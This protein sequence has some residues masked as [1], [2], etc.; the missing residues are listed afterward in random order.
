MKKITFLF[1]CVCISSLS[2]FAQ[3]PSSTTINFDSGTWPS[4]TT[5]V[6]NIDVDIS[7][8]DGNYGMTFG[9][10]MLN[11]TAP[12][13]Y[14]VVAGLWEFAR[15]S[16][17]QD[18]DFATIK[19][20]DG[21]EFNMTEISLRFGGA[22]TVDINGF[23]DGALVATDSFTGGTSF[24]VKTLAPGFA[25]VD[26]IQFQFTSGAA[27]VFRMDD[28][29]FGIA[30]VAGDTTPPV[31]ENS[32]PNTSSIN[33]TNFVLGTDIDEEGT[34]YYVV[35]PDGAVAPTSAEVKAGTG[36]G[37]VVSLTSGNA[38]VSSGA[39]TNDFNVAGLTASTDYDV[40]VV[41]EDDEGTPNLQVT[42]S[43]VDVTT[44]ALI[45]LTIT[46]ITGDDKVYDGTTA[47]TAT[48]TAALSGVV[49]GDDVVLGGTPV[50][51]FA[52]S[53]VGTGITINASGY[54]ISG[55]DAGNYTLTQPTLSGDITSVSLTIT[56]IT[57]DD[58]VYDGTT[59]ATAAGT[60]TLS[61]VVSGDDVVLGGTPVFAFAS[62]DVG[63]GITINGSGYIISG[64][65]AGNYTLTQPTLSG[66]ITSVSLTITGITGDDKV[67]DGTTAATAIGTA[68]LSGVVSGD[69]V[70]LGGT[71]AFAFASSD[72]GTGI[73]I[74]ASGYAI[75]GTDAGNYILTQ[76]TLSADI[77]S[78]SLTIT[79]ITGD[80][81]VYDGTTAATAI[82]TAALSG[83]VSGDDVVLG[84][85]PVFAF[86]SSDVGTGITINASGYAI[87]GTDA[88]NYTLTQPTLS[89]DITSVSLTVTGITGDDKVYDGTTAATATGTA[90][91]SGVV[92]GDDVVL[93]GTPVFAFV[94]SDVGTG[95][96][97]NASGY[98]ISGTDAGN[99]TL[100]QPTL[101][102]DITSVSLT[103]T[104]ITGDDKA[105]DGSTTATVSGTPSLSGIIGSDDVILGGTPVFNFVSPNVGTNITINT[106][107]FTIS[108]ADSGNYDLVQPVLSADITGDVLIID[109]ITTTDVSCN[110]E[111]DGSATVN[112][113]GGTAPYTYELSNGTSSASN[114]FN[115]LEAGNY[116]VTVVD[117][118]NNIITESFVIGGGTTLN[119][120]VSEDQTVY[121]GYLPMSYAWIGVD[122]VSGGAAPY[123]YEW[124]TGETTDRIHVCPTETTIYSVTVTDSN[125]C[126]V[127]EEITVNVVDVR[128]GNH[129][130]NNKVTLCYQGRKTICVPK[131]KVRWYLNRGYTLGACESGNVDITNLKVFPNP[132]RNHL[133]VKFFSTSDV[134]ANIMI[135]NRRGRL[136]FQKNV[137]VREGITRKRL[138][139][140]RLKRGAYYLKIVVNGDVKRTKLIIKR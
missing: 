132:F 107:G 114:V 91:L 3:V 116:D 43:K 82:G 73:T 77:T 42:P 105:F 134:S 45:P 117:A 89:G 87:S 27:T 136:V 4:T 106:T 124:N 57:G 135:Y 67:Y 53:D 31:F 88:G 60:A 70:V 65:D 18:I 34:I 99:Y 127:T 79:G 109:G 19:S 9:L 2:L 122:S 95:I 120:T 138:N 140:S 72:V 113:S 86:A 130:Y 115:G 100:T 10:G 52:S 96:T 84:G 119:F 39:F 98:A 30:P 38:I 25:D 118:A 74:N 80:N 6:G 41:A 44:A 15:T 21:A 108:G 62:S 50:F 94:S 63:T 17:G 66:D 40:Y 54:A 126:S 28:L 14:R 78:V 112:V 137:Q 104:G 37:G 92:S 51:A 111:S 5:G 36:S 20:N 101:S 83:V 58:K 125:G 68:A 13:R 26:E 75:S 123:T 69:D 131:W 49:S 139:L 47:A 16:S 46:G 8:F 121:F 23:K 56:G 128:C 93:D 90:A 64:T 76:P 102:G 85:T 29:V 48:G 129:G 11:A 103:V 7:G 71:P 97:I 32:T 12:Q 1:I 110:G 59:A 24:I 81:K 61:G 22:A 133:N 55:T 35:L 33:Q